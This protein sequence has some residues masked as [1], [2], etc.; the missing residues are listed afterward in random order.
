MQ[1]AGRIK[2]C[3]N[4]PS[5]SEVFRRMTNVCTG[6]EVQGSSKD[7]DGYKK[8]KKQLKRKIVESDEESE[9]EHKEDYLCDDDELDDTSDYDENDICLD[10]NDDIRQEQMWEMQV[11]SSQRNNGKADDIPGTNST[12]ECPNEDSLEGESME[13]VPDTSGDDHPALRGV[14]AGVSIGVVITD[15]EIQ[16]NCNASL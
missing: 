10:Y 2:I 12:S 16:S 4:F 14:A 13:G 8:G 7:S 11:L 15:K 3:N 9:E 1:D 5:L 6:V